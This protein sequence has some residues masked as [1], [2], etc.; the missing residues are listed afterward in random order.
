MEKLKV[1]KM[2]KAIIKG[3]IF[4]EHGAR[5]KSGKETTTDRIYKARTSIRTTIRTTKINRTK[6]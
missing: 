5:K 4:K 3:E 1:I 6:E 2:Q